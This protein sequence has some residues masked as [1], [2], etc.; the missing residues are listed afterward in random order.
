MRESVA[1][2][3]PRPREL[4]RGVPVFGGDPGGDEHGRGQRP[5]RPLRDRVE[6]HEGE[7]VERR[8]DQ[9]RGDGPYGRGVPDPPHGGG[10]PQHEDERRPPQHAP[11]AAARGWLHRLDPQQRDEGHGQ[12]E[13]RPREPGGREE[14]DGER[15][16]SEFTEHSEADLRAQK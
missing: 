13:P 5:G 8:G 10:V 14:R 6:Q 1:E 9:R 15:D 2:D 16:G 11:P 3:E 12:R 4:A 7:E